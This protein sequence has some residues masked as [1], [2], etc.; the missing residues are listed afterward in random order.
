MSIQASSA[1]LHD[2]PSN[3]TNLESLIASDKGLSST[4]AGHGFARCG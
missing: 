3:F 2:R 4:G 1:I